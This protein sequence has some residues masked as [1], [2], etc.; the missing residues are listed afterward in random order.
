MAHDTK[1]AN[2]ARQKRHRDKKRAEANRAVTPVAP[3][4][5][6]VKTNDV[7]QPAALNAK[8][9]HNRLTS[10]GYDAEK[11]GYVAAAGRTARHGKSA[12][13]VHKGTPGDKDAKEYIAPTAVRRFT[14]RVNTLPEVLF[15]EALASASD[16]RKEE[17][18]GQLHKVAR[19]LLPVQR[20]AHP[21]DSDDRLWE[22][23]LERAFV[24]LNGVEPPK[25]A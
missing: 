20:K 8:A 5:G 21:T 7:G 3:I 13:P 14:G 6:G 19:A 2:R 11:L 25:E 22:R 18:L 16:K 4:R 23:A 9:P 12:A 15:A 10:G 1:E 17:L 24:I